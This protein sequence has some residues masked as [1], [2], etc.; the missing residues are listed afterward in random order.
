VART[1]LG[2]INHTLLTIEAM[3]ARSIE[4]AG[5]MMVGE[6]NAEN[7]F[8]IEQYGRVPVVGDLPL[9]D[10]LTPAALGAWATANLDV[11]HRLPL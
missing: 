11:H 1:G 8:A 9:L 3:R 7:R 2:T 6:P 4:V 5:V 10:P